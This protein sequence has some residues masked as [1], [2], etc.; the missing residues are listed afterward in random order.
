MNDVQNKSRLSNK[1]IAFRGDNLQRNE[2]SDVDEYN[3][4][5]PNALSNGGPLGRGELNG[6]IGTGIDVSKRLELLSKNEF[7]PTKEYTAWV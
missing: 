4:Q 7:Q 2:Y 6:V 3:R 1:N 5:H